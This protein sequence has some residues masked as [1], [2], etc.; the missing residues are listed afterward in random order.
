M[1]CFVR[2]DSLVSTYASQ[3]SRTKWITCPASMVSTAI[4]VLPNEHREA[5][6]IDNNAA[7]GISVEQL[8]SSIET[9]TGTKPIICALT[10]L[11]LDLSGKICVF[12]EELVHP[13]Y[14]P[15]Q[16]QF[17]AIHKFVSVSKGIP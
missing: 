6:I 3:V 2:L 4:E 17:E 15:Q 16:E 10:S 7:A 11:P 13:L 8:T 14:D 1:L 9:L 12:L 5:V